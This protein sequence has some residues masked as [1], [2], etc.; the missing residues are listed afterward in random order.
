MSDALA[1][2][3]MTIEEKLQRICSAAGLWQDVLLSKAALELKDL[4]ISGKD[5]LDIGIRQG[6]E[7]G[8]LLKM[9][10]EYVLEEPERNKKEFLLEWIGKNF[11]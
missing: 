1:Q 4:Q 7:L 8:K 11:L 2:N 5:L 3:P 10:L 9:A 6:P